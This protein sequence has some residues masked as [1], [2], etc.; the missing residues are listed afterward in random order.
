MGDWG[1]GKKCCARVIFLGITLTFQKDTIWY[2]SISVISYLHV[3]ALFG[4]CTL[5]LDLMRNLYIYNACIYIHS[6]S[7]TG[8]DGAAGGQI[9][10][11]RLF[12]T[13]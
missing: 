6:I 1:K 5:I 4:F 3:L 12:I 13:Q 11:P 2:V 8:V 10:S 9:L 7:L